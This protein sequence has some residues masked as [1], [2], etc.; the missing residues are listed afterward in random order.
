MTATNMPILKKDPKTAN[1]ANINKSVGVM[2]KNLRHLMEKNKVDTATL[3]AATKLAVPTINSLRRGEG[4]PTL[5]TLIDLAHYFEVSIGDLTEGDLSIEKTAKQS[6]AK[7]VPF[8]KINEIDRFLGNQLKTIETYTIEIDDVDT[9]TCFAVLVNNDSLYPQF[10]P[11]TVLIVSRDEKPLDNDI[12]LIKISDLNPCFRKIHF[13]ENNFLFSSVSIENDSS[14]S[15]YE[16]YEL[17][18]V[19]LKAVKTISGR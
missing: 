16:K 19:L 13:S 7:S 4:N 15:T 14:L 17:I 10:S 11:G 12:V 5:S 6:S 18:G 2:A 1:T 3:N 8:I 9:A